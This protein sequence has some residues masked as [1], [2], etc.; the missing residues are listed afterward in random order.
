MK[1]LG[2][3][4]V[5]IHGCGGQQGVEHIQVAAAR[6]GRDPID[7][8]IGCKDHQTKSHQTVL[9]SQSAYTCAKQ[10]GQQQG[11]GQDVFDDQ[12]GKFYQTTERVLDAMFQ[13][14]TF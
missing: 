3:V 2:I 1:S 14:R 13:G 9:T 10:E 11:R 6:A 4:Q 8:N 12:E 7:P 5:G